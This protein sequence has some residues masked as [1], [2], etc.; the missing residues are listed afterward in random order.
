MTT[1][2]FIR[3]TGDEAV[4]KLRLQKLRSGYPFMINSSELESNH[5]YLEYPDGTIMLVYLENS[6]RD[7]KV[8]RE[9]TPA[10]E[11]TVRERY[12]LS[13]L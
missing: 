8:V 11:Q 5:C 12:G 7:F 1:L 4:K 13:R 2:Q 6:A 9:L 3:K 10:E